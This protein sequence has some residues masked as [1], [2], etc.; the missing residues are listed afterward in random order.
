M[1]NFTDRVKSIEAIEKRN[2]IAQFAWLIW[3]WGLLVVMLVSFYFDQHITQTDVLIGVILAFGSV[4][5]LVLLDGWQVEYGHN[6]DRLDN[7]MERRVEE[8]EDE[9]KY[10]R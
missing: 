3:P 8:L 7:L 6:R 4:I 2:K 10:T 1:K 5:H 9:I